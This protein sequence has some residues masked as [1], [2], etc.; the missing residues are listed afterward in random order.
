M[1]F[2]PVAAAADITNKY[3][4]YLRT[5]FRFKD[6]EY[7]TQFERLLGDT[8]Q[9]SKGPFLDVTDSFEKG[10]SLTALI[11]KG[12][13]PKGVARLNMNQTRTLYLH[14]QIATEK[15]LEGRNVVVSTGTGSGKTESFLIPILAELIREHEA[16][17]LDPG[18][19]A[20]IIYPMN[21]LANDQIERL[22]VILKDY[23][24]ITYGSYTGQTKETYNE[25]LAEYR[26]LNDDQQPNP[27]ELICRRQMKDAPPHIMITN[28]AMLEYLM[29]RPDDSV[30][31][32][33]DKAFKWRYIVLDEAHVY[34]GST[35]IEVSMLL[36]RLRATLRNDRIK[37][38]LTSA[39][40]GD[41]NSDGEVA[42]FASKLCDARFEAED[43]IRA[44]RV[45]V[46][47]EK[48]TIDL[49]VE[50]YNELADALR[51]DEPDRSKVSSIISAYVPANNDD[52]EISE[53]IYDALLIDR[54]FLKVKQFLTRPRRVS[55]ISAT[56]GWN[57]SDTE[58]F[59]IVASKAF[60]N[61]VHLF[62]ARYH[63][64]LRATESAFITLKPQKRLFLNRMEYYE[65]GG[66]RYRVFEVGTCS[67][68]HSIFIVGDVKN[69]VLRQSS[70]K[71]AAGSASVFLLADD[72][73]DTDEDFLMDAENMNVEPYELCPYCGFIRKA[74]VTDGK[75]KKRHCA[76]DEKSFVRVWKILKE[77][78]RVYKCP[79]CEATSPTGI[80]RMFFAGQ[81]AV[82]SVIGTALFEA[83]P[84]QRELIR[85]H[86][87][88]DDDSGFGFNSDSDEK[89]IINEAKQF[90]AFS[91]SR[92]AAAY[93][94]TYMDKTYKSIL[95]KRMILDCLE[96]NNN[97][98][99]SSLK[100]LVNDLTGAF[101]R[102]RVFAE[103]EDVKKEAWIA[104]LAELVDNNGN[105]SLNRMGLVDI[106][107]SD[108][109]PVPPNGKWNLSESEVRSIIN[110]FL[111][112]MLSSAAVTQKEV[113]INKA[114]WAEIA[115]G[116]VSA[117]F[118]Y[119]D[120]DAKHYIK[121]F[122]PT[123][124]SLSNKR[125]DY[126]GKIAAKVKQPDD[127]EN[128]VNFL[129]GLWN[130]ILIKSA[131]SILEPEN[132]TY[133]VNAENLTFRTTTKCYKCSKCGRITHN[134][135]KGVCPAYKCDG[136]LEPIDIDKEY[137]DNHYYE[138]YKNL[139]PRPLRIVE[140]TAQLS[141]DE[142]YEYQKEFK[143]KELDV[144]SCSTTFEMG[145]DVGSLET[146]FMRNMPPSPSNYAQRAGR[147]GRSVE[148]A[149]FAL[150]FCNKSN[151][152]FT[153]F[154][155]PVKMIKGKIMPPS[156]NV[157]NE[158]IAV[159][160]I[161]ASAIAFFWKKHRDYFAKSEVMLGRG[162][163]SKEGFDLLVDYIKSKPEDLK[164]YIKSFLPDNLSES[165]DVEHFGWIDGLIGTEE[166]SKGVLVKAV[167]EYWNDVGILLEE[168]KKRF[169][170]MKGTG[171]VDQR[172]RTLY[173]E[174]ILSF[175]A[176]KGVFPRYGFP[177]DTVELGIDADGAKDNVF[178]LQLNRDL[179]MA[180]SEYAPGSQVVANGNLITSR[181]IRK[182]PG[183]LWKMYDFKNCPECKSMSIGLH[184]DEGK[185]LPDDCPVCSGKI[186]SVPRSTF[187]I[188]ELGFISDSKG[189]TKPGL[190]K[191]KRTYNNEIAY[192][193]H[194]DDAFTDASIGNA[195]IS[196]MHSQKDEMVVI[197]NSNF[198]VCPLCG[199]AEVDEGSFQPRMMIKHRSPGGRKACSEKM[200]TRR[201][202]G[203]M[204]QTSVLQ[205]RFEDPILPAGSEE[206][207][208]YAYSVLQG[209]LRGVCTYFSIDE[210]DISG[211]LQYYF[212]RD[213]HKGAY[214]I[215]LYDATPGGSG[216]VNMINSADKLENV[217]KS[218]RDI[219]LSCDC[220]GDAADSSCYSCLRNYY[221][222]R[223]HDVMKRGYVI[224]FVNSVLSANQ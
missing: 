46:L 14:Q 134:N 122:I 49:P 191:P 209:M 140:H 103:N 110:E 123:K 197:N 8:D 38:V 119:S 136:E 75:G 98:S 106:G 155:D 7:Q 173:N 1:A 212:N 201:S 213:T 72:Y 85:V 74:N 117:S 163:D 13:L 137:A 133:R 32:E 187:I 204:F 61:G 215:I 44:H 88:E 221:N 159:R 188:P 23:P 114:D 154:N 147:A 15:A 80:L 144:L 127:R 111:L 63:M 170:E 76:H 20:M 175:F 195:K 206:D 102:H 208:A 223:Y 78:E 180:I 34:T 216:Y 101:E 91:D 30:F 89:L 124:V 198:F 109:I 178:G 148:S 83:I 51:F 96:K 77:S 156:F 125:V 58:N 26:K 108:R 105:T 210:R 112:S 113:P 3:K 97:L 193:G 152:D 71:E 177:V 87:E 157:E 47:P 107:L 27:N 220:G 18:V 146:V 149:A 141:R 138:L 182:A 33:K 167:E 200:L 183:M 2:L 104:V 219:A 56:L 126:I 135:V 184:T 57:D 28:Y 64:F 36:R 166:N 68:C 161:Y 131:A 35:G 132:G 211:C 37:Y 40:L 171:F 199:Y 121:A 224:D 129:K 192:I 10:D 186:K 115:P 150:T 120:S 53:Q 5:I 90:I 142:A 73:N 50:F 158:K 25:A 128:C 9:L 92:Q 84:S 145:V 100:L 16:G 86:Y 82:T 151:H 202:L 160:H 81:E 54:T 59:V 66:E 176:R 12:T 190:I 189:V 95:Y 4:R 65:D 165:L 93:Y 203:Y 62:D 21:A 222:Q 196:M 169:E 185:Q 181:Y 42:L 130:C 11:E 52:Q 205:I 174:S 39:T 139:E 48:G 17:T 143:N 118:S 19:R 69:E 172:L 116:G 55:E 162:T 60:K 207:W 194:K 41:K 24:E 168:R 70:S 153:F 6:P 217:L 214:S 99:G 94:A 45:D 29:V 67:S 43:V 218:A 179:S 22:R 164:E 79:A 31:F